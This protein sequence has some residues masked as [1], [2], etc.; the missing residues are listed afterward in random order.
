M[1]LQDTGSIRRSHWKILS[2]DDVSFSKSDP[3]L[4][5]STYGMVAFTFLWFYYLHQ[6]E[7]EFRC[8]VLKFAKEKGGLE[9]KEV[10]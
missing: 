10:G 4:I 9:G 2:L 1:A 7:E 6:D 8:L 3:F 5:S